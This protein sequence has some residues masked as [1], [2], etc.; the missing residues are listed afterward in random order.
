MSELALR[1]ELEEI[2]EKYASELLTIKRNLVKE[3]VEA[4]V[5]YSI[6]KV[7]SLEECG[8]EAKAIVE[9]TFEVLKNQL[10]ST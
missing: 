9:K 3:V 1:K 8:K 6:D 7:L 10:E 5:S 2:V 4:V